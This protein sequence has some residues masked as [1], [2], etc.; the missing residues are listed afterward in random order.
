MAVLRSPL[1]GLSLDE[2]ATIRLAAP[3]VHF[4]TALN[5][6]QKPSAYAKRYG[7]TSEARNQ[8]TEAETVKKDLKS[9]KQK[10]E[11]ECGF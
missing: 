8:K 2:L 5:R 3:H 11:S 4:W 6:S 9:G 10:S 1:V 7:E